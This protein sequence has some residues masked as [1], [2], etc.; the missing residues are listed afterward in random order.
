MNWKTLPTVHIY[1]ISADIAF[2]HAWGILANL[3]EY[4]IVATI[5]SGLPPKTF[6]RISIIQGHLT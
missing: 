6:Y 4:A 2:L 3:V 5:G 1:I